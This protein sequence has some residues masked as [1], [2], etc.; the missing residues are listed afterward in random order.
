MAIP[1]S[2]LAGINLSGVL[3]L[4]S[5]AGTS[6]QILISQGTGNTPTWT[7][8][9]NLLSPLLTRVDST[10]EGG[11]INFA[12]SSDGNAYWFIDSFGTAGTP[13]G[14]TPDLRFIE[15]ATER[16]RFVSGGALSI[17]GQTGTSGQVLTS[18]GGSSAPTWT[19]SPTF[20]TLTADQVLATNNGN[21]TN[22]KVGDDVWL[23]D[24][25]VAN[26]MSLKGQQSATSGYIRFGGDTNA[27]GYD[28]TKLSYAGNLT[29]SGLTLSS[30]TSPIIL[31]A[32]AGTSGQV[33][34]SAGAG[35]TPTWTSVSG[36]LGYLG[37]T[38]TTSGSGG[39]S[40]LAG[41]NT[42]TPSATASIQPSSV[43]TATGIGVSLIAGATSAST[44][45]PTGG[46]VTITG[47][48]Q[49]N[50][51][52]L[53]NGGSISITGGASGTQ[54]IGGNITIT[55]GAG[56]AN[57]GGNVTINAGSS[58]GGNGSMS[59]GTSNTDAITIGITGKSTTINAGLISL[60]AGTSSISPLKFTA[61]TNL[62]TP[63]YGAVEAATDAIY[64]TNNPGS[65][66]T[67][68]GRG[69][70]LAPQMVFSLA[71]SSTS[72]NGAATSVFASA[73]DV[74][75][76]LEANKLYRF[77]AKYYSSF[78]YAGAAGTISAIFAFS[79][80][81]VAIKYSYTTY[82]QTAGTTAIT[83]MGTY[84]TTA[85][86]A[87][88]PSQSASG[89]WVTEID[90][91]FTTHATLTSTLTPQFSQSGTSSTTVMTAGSWFEVEKLGTAS[92][93][94]IAGNWA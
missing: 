41:V 64:V 92:T 56:G 22:F 40:T 35:A 77:R 11:Q 75:S 18:A 12:R 67:G 47:G 84:A 16:F 86:S 25:N 9:L 5:S 93:T 33:L 31:N 57:G 46:S 45:T 51:T 43:A 15:N 79:N 29:T 72:T 52:V 70:I 38:Q 94:L 85:A 34:T 66:S 74:L 19:S 59:I 69:V 88:A 73:N 82:S 87:I 65:T 6:G 76:V 7:S 17:N 14:S 27:F 3:Q 37:T 55:G 48:A 21:G 1:R 36:S 13:S 58:S 2:F 30:T 28:G 20:S 32:S 44:G 89:S 26:T 81:P 23:G 54:G 71:N 60:A 91:Y 39:T 61:G 24:I 49:T 42:F 80:A 78:T 68:P 83:S 53:G 10:S 63:S 50:G 8:T 4:S 62:T 90:G